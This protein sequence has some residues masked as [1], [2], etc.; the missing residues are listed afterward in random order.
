MVRVSKDAG[1]YERGDI[2]FGKKSRKKLRSPLSIGEK[3][4][5]LAERLRKKDAPGN[6]Y[7]STTENISFFNREQVFI[8]RKVLPRDDSYD[9][10][11]SKTEDGEILHKRFL[12]QE[13]FALRNQFV[14]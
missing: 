5:V 8:V 4:L 2:Q 9:Y 12:W 10:W 3:V 14:E 6:F 7:K 11:V 13:L 1:R